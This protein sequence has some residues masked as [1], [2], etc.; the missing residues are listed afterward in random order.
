MESARILHNSLNATFKVTLA[1]LLANPTP[2]NRLF[3][4]TLQADMFTATRLMMQTSRY[5]TYV[6]SMLNVIAVLTILLF[7]VSTVFQII[8]IV[9]YKDS[10]AMYD[11]TLNGSDLDD[12]KNCMD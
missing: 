8:E 4:Q 3:M 11:V 10:V 1:E 12:S 7:I 5:V 9:K 6:T 2:I